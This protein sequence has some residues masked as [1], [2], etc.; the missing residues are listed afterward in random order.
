M[1]LGFMFVLC[2]A[3]DECASEVKREKKME[4]KK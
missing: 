2:L 1:A 3:T 4:I